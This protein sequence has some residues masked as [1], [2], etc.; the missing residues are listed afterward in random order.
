MTAPIALGS[1][2][3]QDVWRKYPQITQMNL[4]NLW[5]LNCFTDLDGAAFGAD[6]SHA[7]SINADGRHLNIDS[8][9]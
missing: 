3:N 2:H 1:S 9:N 6:H 5:I 8:R 4:R 7:W